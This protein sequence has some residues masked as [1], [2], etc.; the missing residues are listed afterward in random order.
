[1]SPRA[2]AATLPKVTKPVLEKRGTA[3]AT[4]IAQWSEIFGPALADVTMP[5][6]LSAAAPGGPPG[7][8]LTIRVTSGAAADVQHLAP[9]LIERMNT[10]LGFAAVTRLKLVQAPMPQAAPR[11]GRPRKRLSPAAEQA[12]GKAVAGVDDPAL[13]AALDRL[14]RAVWNRADPEP[15]NRKG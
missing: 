12:V 8:T 5:E 6:R 3:F 4:L 14:G 11:T 10:F 9:Q 1:M 2:L 7:G 13:R 15:G